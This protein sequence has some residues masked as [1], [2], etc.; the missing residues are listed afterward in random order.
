MMIHQEALEH[1]YAEPSE[2]NQIEEP[3]IHSSSSSMLS[4]TL[5]KKNRDVVTSRIKLA[6]PYHV[7]H[8]NR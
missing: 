5:P 2:G 1:D 4:N 7:S 3:V 6:A 8:S